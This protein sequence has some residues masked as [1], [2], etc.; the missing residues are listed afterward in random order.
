M[1]KIGVDAEENEPIGKSDVIL[2]PSEGE[3]FGRSSA[4]LEITSINILIF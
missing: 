2:L 3:P 4:G 1:T